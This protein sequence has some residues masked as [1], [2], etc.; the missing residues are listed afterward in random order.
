MDI[1]LIINA[2][3]ETL[4]LNSISTFTCSGADIDSK[5]AAIKAVYGDPGAEIDDTNHTIKVTENETISNITSS[6]VAG[7]KINQNNTKIKLPAGALGDGKPEIIFT[8]Q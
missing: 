8:K 2:S 1:N 3:A 6:D 5:W 4:T 7:L